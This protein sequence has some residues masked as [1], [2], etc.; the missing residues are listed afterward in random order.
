MT[1]KMTPPLTKKVALLTA[2]GLSKFG[3]ENTF[4]SIMSIKPNHLHP[5]VL[6]GFD[7]LILPGVCGE[8]SPYPEILS[9]RKAGFI[10]QAVEQN[11]LIVLAFCAA[12]YYLCDRIEYTKRDNTTIKMDGLGWVE[13]TAK[14][15]FAHITRQSETP[16]KNP[17]KSKDYILAELN[18]ENI[19]H[20]LRSLNINGPTLLLSEKEKGLSETFIK[21]ASIEGAAGLVKSCG[22]GKLI[23]LGV[24]PEFPLAHQLLPE[25][26]AAYSQD[27][28]TL[29][30]I[31]AQKTGI[32][33]HPPIDQRILSYA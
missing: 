22:K 6:S 16:D 21:Y 2:H 24:H 1:Q 27:H 33:P 9:D 17:D 20:P 12:A 11:G 8:E 15:A 26:F 5:E 30:E 19:A 29:L 25:S 14:H 7:M 31:I 23:L 4:A 10:K 18:V 28:T 32:H 3:F 13:A